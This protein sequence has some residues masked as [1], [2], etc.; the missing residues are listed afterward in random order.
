MT[1]CNFSFFRM[2]SLL[3]F[4]L[5]CL[6]WQFTT[7]DHILVKNTIKLIY[8]RI[9]Q[10]NM[11]FLCFVGGTFRGISEDDTSICAADYLSE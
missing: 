4:K 5:E 7:N 10:A 6:K 11:S 9:T 1:A 2:S 3:I 8:E